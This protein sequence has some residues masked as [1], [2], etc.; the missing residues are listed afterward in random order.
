MT[1]WKEAWPWLSNESRRFLPNQWTYNVYQ[2]AL[3]R[4][5][6][7][8]RNNY[9]RGAL[10][11]MLNNEELFKESTTCG[12]G[13]SLAEGRNVRYSIFDGKLS[14]VYVFQVFGSKI[15]AEAVEKPIQILSDVYI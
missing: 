5:I 2:R 13:N 9:N 11:R 3:G 15:W 8:H 1:I 12:I 14:N 4:E 10:G 6:G 7:Y